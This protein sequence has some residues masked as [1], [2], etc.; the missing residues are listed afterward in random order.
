MS[1]PS[2]DEIKSKYEYD[3]VEGI[4]Y[5]KDTK[6]NAMIIDRKNST[7]P[8]YWTV[9]IAGT[10]YTASRVAHLLMTGFWPTGRT[11]YIDGD[12][13]NLKWNNLVFKEK[14]ENKPV[15]SNF[16]RALHASEV[17]PTVAGRIAKLA[18]ENKHPD[19]Y[20]TKLSNSSKAP[21]WVRDIARELLK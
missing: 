15:C 8:S 3:H 11:R 10:M 2:V 7:V 6:L 9:K 19:E 5:Y 21:L 12:S 1:I 14:E 13:T 18:S 16:E 17:T 20:L 4:I